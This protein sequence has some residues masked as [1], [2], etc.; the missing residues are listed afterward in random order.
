[1]DNLNIEKFLQELSN[2]K[3]NI[4]N[5]PTFNIWSRHNQNTDLYHQKNPEINNFKENYKD[6][7]KKE[8]NI[9]PRYTATKALPITNHT[10]DRLPTIDTFNPG[11]KV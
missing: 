9:E 1:M 11:N 6:F 4:K 10:I 3:S 7:K 5:T 2:Q 8:I